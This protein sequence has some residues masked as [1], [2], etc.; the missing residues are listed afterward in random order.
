[1]LSQVFLPIATESS[2]FGVS[3]SKRSL[4]AR[5]MMFGRDTLKVIALGA[6]I[7]VG[8]V[9]QSTAQHSQ[10]P[11]PSQEVLAQDTTPAVDNQSTFKLRERWTARV[12]WCPKGQSA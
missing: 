7:T 2:P 3:L 6:A 10:L 5:L 8:L 11:M 1:M 12:G 9:L 4:L